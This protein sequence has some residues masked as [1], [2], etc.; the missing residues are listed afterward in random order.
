MILKGNQRSGGWQLAAHLLNT[1]DNEHVCVHELRGFVAD[2]LEG[3]F[4][5][6]YAASKGT[7]AETYL[8]SLSLNPPAKERVS[9]EKFQSAI[10][11]AEKHLGLAGQPRAIVFHEK[12]GRRHAHA[13]WSRIDTA[14]MRAIDLALYKLR[15]RDVARDLYI[16]HGWQLPRG[17]INSEERMR[18]RYSHHECQQARREGQDPAALKRM[19]QECWAASD[20]RKAFAAA[21][22]ARGYTLARGNRRGHVALDYGARFTRFPSMSASTPNTSANASASGRVV[23]RR[24]GPIGQRQ[25][26]VGGP[27]AQ[28]R[29][30]GEG[31]PG[32]LRRPQVPIHT[33]HSAP[34]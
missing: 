13:I 17:F 14:N 15:L 12:D 22:E 24:E 5:E 4:Q 34:A 26:H 25:A 29:T 16:E 11:R 2:D 28:Y 7:R 32:T 3:A 8:F 1:R 9:T 20:S 10:E 19:F 31:Q 23:E 27:Q 21:L 33:N 6:V 30:G 18:H